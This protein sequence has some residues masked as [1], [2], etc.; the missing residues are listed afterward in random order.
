MVCSACGWANQS[1][2]FPRRNCS[3]S[4]GASPP[5]KEPREIILDFIREN[6]GST[7]DVICQ[8]AGKTCEAGRAKVRWWLDGLVIEG[9]LKNDGNG[10]SLAEKAAKSK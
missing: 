10:Y 9:T 8:G 7:F 3:K 2:K 4:L 1:G 6:P 5:R